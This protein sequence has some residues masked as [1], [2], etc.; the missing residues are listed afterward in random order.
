MLFH[1]IPPYPPTGDI[2][3]VSHFHRFVNIA[4]PQEFENSL[5]IFIDEITFMEYFSENT[6]FFSTVRF[7]Y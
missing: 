6:A 4:P 5:R 1:P 7:F 3:S 2:L